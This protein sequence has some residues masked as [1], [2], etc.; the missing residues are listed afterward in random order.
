MQV[1]TSIQRNVCVFI[2][3][4]FLRGI[5]KALQIDLNLKHSYRHLEILGVKLHEYIH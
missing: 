5:H 1:I 3:I 2:F 4:C